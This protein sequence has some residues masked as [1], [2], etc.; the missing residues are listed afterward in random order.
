MSMPQKTDDLAARRAELLAREPKLRAYDVARAL[1]VG[2]AALL[3]VDPAARATPLRP[4]FAA[5]LAR[6]KELGRVM[7][8]T[9][10]AAAVHER[11]GVYE[12]FSAEGHA[13]L[14]L[15]PDIDLRLFLGKWTFGFALAPESPD[16]RPS[17]QFFDAAGDAV[18]KVHAIED[19]DMAAWDRL[20]ADFAGPADAPPPAFAPRAAVPVSKPDS[21][22]DVGA[23]RAGWRALKDTHDFFGL[24]RKSG[25]TRLQAMRL[26]GPE[27][28]RPLARTDLRATLERAAAAG[29]PIMVFVGNPGCIQI[30]TGPVA[31]IVP[32]GPWINVLDPVFNLHA[33]EDLIG[34]VWL[35]RKPTD[36]GTVTSVEVFD[37]SDANVA[38]LFG[39]RKPGKPEL[40][41]WRDLAESLADRMAA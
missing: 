5:L 9:R 32:M 41:A 28:A 14:V 8:L 13:A 37:E 30:H 20:V 18:H 17:L 12:N 31:R 39:A 15:G 3:A 1:G 22:I 10:N 7:A 33:R 40:P 35:V 2:E 19:T 16:R 21:A 29:T 25:A 6:F 38:M 4:E 36:D 11:K 27:F 26:A 23:L 24:V 34:S